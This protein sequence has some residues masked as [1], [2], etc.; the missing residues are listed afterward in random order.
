[1]NILVEPLKAE[2]L[3]R[4]RSS[5]EAHLDWNVRKVLRV[6][7]I[8]KKWFAQLV[9]FPLNQQ[10]FKKITTVLTIVHINTNREFS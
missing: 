6:C 9:P 3:L 10:L 2:L 7:F 4:Q 8:K 5:S 1:M